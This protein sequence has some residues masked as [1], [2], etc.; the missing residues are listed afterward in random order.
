MIQET[1]KYH[2]IDF[3][4]EGIRYITGPKN[5]KNLFRWLHCGTHTYIFRNVIE[6]AKY[7]CPWHGKGKMVWESIEGRKDGNEAKKAKIGREV[8]EGRKHGD[9][10]KKECV[11][12]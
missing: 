11:V 12:Q 2:G 3:M 7:E 5:C 1:D 4:Y 6:G 8:M 10:A 9:E